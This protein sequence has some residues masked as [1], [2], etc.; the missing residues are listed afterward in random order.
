M[1]LTAKVKLEPSEDQC[2]ALLATIHQANQCCHWLS[3]QAW[4]TKKFRAYDLH[5]VAYRRAREK[6]SLGAQMV[7]RCIAKVAEAYQSDRDRKRSFR[8]LGSVAYDARML[9]WR[10]ENQ[11]ISIWSLSGRLNIPFACGPR[12]RELLRWQHGESD[13][14]Y[15]RG[16]FY[17]AATCE[18]EESIPAEPTDALGVDLGVV[19]IAS[20]SDGQRY[21][22]SQTRSVRHRCR[23]LRAKLQK[24]QTR[25]AKRRLQKLSGKER[26]FATYTNHVISK[27]IVACAKRTKRSIV[28]EDL[29]GIRLRI[30]ARRKQRAVL[31]SWAFSQL[32]F[33]ITY[34]AALAGVLLVLVDPRDTSR[35]CSRCGHIAKENRPNQSTFCCAVCHY[36]APADCNAALV[37][38]SR[39]AVNPPRASARLSDVCSSTHT[40]VKSL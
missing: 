34:K 36:S 11:A 1:K 28:L 3:E 38:R 18:I 4:N 10:V 6:F 19:N 32:R 5:H 31:H 37:I 21:S 30:R 39:A 12:Q 8:S 14:I 17:L 7:V 20:D 40:L 22:G 29:R 23:R 27:Q 13:L 26:R 24:K 35:E 2:T 25:A 15:S 16:T 33:F 9:R